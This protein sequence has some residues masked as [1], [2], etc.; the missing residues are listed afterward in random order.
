MWNVYNFKDQKESDKIFGWVHNTLKYKIV[1]PIVNLLGKQ[2]DKHVDYKM[3]YNNHTKIYFAFSRALENTNDK[4]FNEWGLKTYYTDN[5]KHLR[6]MFQKQFGIIENFKKIFFTICKYDTAYDTFF[7]IFSFEFVKE[8]QNTFRQDKYIP[9]FAS[10]NANDV[11]YMMVQ[12]GFAVIKGKRYR[13]LLEE[14]NNGN[15][16]TQESK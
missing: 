5:A 16:K 8:I 2:V 13:V 6:K 15:V 12:D 3:K 10:R 7:K 4:W 14:D 11:S 9:L 1:V